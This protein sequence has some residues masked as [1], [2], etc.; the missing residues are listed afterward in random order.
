MPSLKDEA[1]LLL[2][3]AGGESGAGS[4]L[5]DFSDALV[6][7]GRALDVLLGANLVLDLSCLWVC[8]LVN[9]RGA[10]EG[11]A[12]QKTYLILGDGGLRSLVKLFDG[13]SVVSKILL[14]TDENDGKA[15]AK[16][17]NLG[18]PLQ[19]DP[20]LAHDLVCEARE[21]SRRWSLPSL[22]RCPENR[23]NRWQNR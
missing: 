10:E 11:C 22:E 4:V 8:M 3:L 20:W 16:V 12:E 5:K 17:Q 19:T 6:G 21:Q 2:L 13:L 9:A 14:A 1:L 23:A 18:D 15:L 7:L